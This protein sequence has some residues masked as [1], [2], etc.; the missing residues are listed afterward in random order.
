MNNDEIRQLIDM[1][2][3]CGRSRLSK[4]TGYVHHCYHPND[5]E[6]NDTIPIVENMMFALALL[7]SRTS[8]N[9]MEA[10]GIIERLLHFQTGDGNFP[11]YLHEFPQ[12][13]DR[14]IGSHLLPIFYWMLR[15]FNTVLGTELLNKLQA[16][17]IKQLQF[18]L[19]T[20]KEKAGPY[21]LELKIAASAKAL[22]ELLSEKKFQTEGEMLL[23][24][25]ASSPDQA[26]RS[27]P[28]SLADILVGLQ[29]VYTSLA[30]SPWKGF[31]EYLNRTWHGPTKTYVGPPMREFQQ[32]A[33]PQPSA[34][35]LFLGYFS[36]GFSKRALA[37]NIC[38]LYGALIAPT[39]DRLNPLSLPISEKGEIYECR[40]EM[41]QH[42]GFA[43]CALE[44]QE[45][46]RLCPDRG[47]HIF[48]MAWGNADRAHTFVCQG[49]N[50]S[51]STFQMRNNGCDLFFELT[52][53][54]IIEDR[55]KNR[56]VLFYFDI[57]DEVEIT[58][59]DIPATT[60]Q[61]GENVKIKSGKMALSLQFT[62]EEGQGQFFGHIMPGNRLSQTAV[63][64]AQRFNA[65]DWQVL[66][67]TVRR[68]GRCKLKALCDFTNTSPKP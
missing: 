50:S 26:S 1:A 18:C 43:V 3:R 25:L 44:Q 9:I 8:E 6:K 15:T 46:G 21:H 7:Q 66:L 10:R 13:R 42:N 31:W 16:A 67:R 54:P 30:N 58:V 29:L 2:V 34:Y 57:P 65:Y 51:H 41:L 27:S 56:E 59:Q 63:R 19:T 48:R 55:E 4:Q 36:G 61:L 52:E 11:V 17:A 38:H 49:G 40:W 60:F 23:A 32:G 28:A 37:D 64:G 39:N 68:S 47:R 14:L 24:K 45:P 33:E 53:D 62:L 5:E 20:I 35:D 22:G 12:S